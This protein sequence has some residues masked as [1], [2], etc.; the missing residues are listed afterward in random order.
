MVTTVRNSICFTVAML[1][2]VGVLLV[3]SAAR[4]SAG[5]ATN[6]GPRVSVVVTTAT[7]SRALTKMPS[8]RFGRSSSRGL[9]VLHVDDTVRYQRITGFGAAMTDSS[10][11]LIYTQLPAS[12]REFAM[13]Q[14]FGPSGIHLNFVRVPIGASDF[15]EGG[16][17]YS[18]DDMP[19]G[20][21]DPQLQNFSIE[22]DTAYITPVL[23]EMLDLNPG[24]SILA[25][26]W[27]P[28]AWMKANDALDNQRGLGTLLPSAY[29]PLAEYFVKFIQAY[30]AEGIPISAISPQNEPMAQT[31]Y[32]G[33]NISPD[34]EAQFIAQ[35]L[36]PALADA[37]LHPRIYGLDRGAQFF[38]AQ[39]LMSSQARADLSGIAWHCY[40][41]QPVM[42]Q[43]HQLDPAI[44]QVI[45]ECSPGIIPYS[46]SEAA[47]SGTRN[48]A[49]AV[50]LWNL[51]L[52]PSGGPVQP[53]NTGCRGCR[54]LLTVSESLQTMRFNTSFFQLGQVS[55]FVQPGAVRISSDRWVS[56]FQNPTGYGVT[57]GLDNVAFVNPNGTKVL[58]AYNNSRAR[59]SFAIQWRGQAFP[60][61]LPAGATA[62][63]SWR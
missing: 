12:L 16:V 53:I 41:G 38:Y 51:A 20:Q 57:S 26:P 58:V 8:I 1:A 52:D 9:R 40:G 4:A 11:W 43:L 21:S 44:E 7:L 19:A 29:G 23:R 25:N 39:A 56:D 24:V 37:G 14:L 46:A 31:T 42:A 10:A 62:T 3:A 22:H 5:T 2:A 45:S 28:P 54:G 60:Y 33:M 18:Y 15:T 27:S 6:L 49:S 50:A 55:K 36:E 61:A 13:G 32:P 63:F 47:I 17:P 30:E 34:N 35:Y 48:W 59:L